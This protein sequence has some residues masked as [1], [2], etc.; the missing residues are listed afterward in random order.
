M[1]EIRLFADHER[2]DT[3]KSEVRSASKAYAPKNAENMVVDNDELS[4]YLSADIN[5]N[6]ILDLGS[7]R[8]L[9][10]IEWVPRNDDNFIR[11]G[12]EYVL[13]YQDGRRGWVSLETK[14]GTDSILTFSSV[15]TNAL[16]RLHDITRG[17]EENV[18]I[19][20]EGKQVFLN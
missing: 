13:L 5:A 4:Y 10:T 2:K 7:E 3:I 19:M 18:F 16:L 17:V 15:P 20:Q 6:L 8:K 12:D 11:H 1:G 14:A 9:S